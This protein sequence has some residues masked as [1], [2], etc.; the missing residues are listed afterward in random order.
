MAEQNQPAEPGGQDHDDVV[1]VPDIKVREPTEYEKR[2]R[3]ESARYRDQARTAEARAQQLSSEFDAFKSAAA[4]ERDAALAAL[5]GESETAVAAARTEVQQRLIRAELKAYA[6]RAGIV[7]L[8][9]LRLADLSGV[10]LNDDGEVEGAEALIVAMKEAKPYLF[11]AVTPPGT[12]TGTTAPAANP[13]RPQPPTAFDA[14]TASRED[15]QREKARVLGRV[16]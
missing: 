9:A 13:P 7:D 12:T 2:L 1:E 4:T 14:R 5:R 6:I 10:K 8:D 15:Y 11:G 3:R 16:S